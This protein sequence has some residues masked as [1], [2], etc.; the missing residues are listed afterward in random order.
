MHR[1]KVILLSFNYAN[2]FSLANGYLKV[3][4]EKDPFIRDTASIQLLDFDA[5]KHDIRQVLYYLAR[6]QPAIV[7]FS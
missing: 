5:E 6:E 2:H 1:S 3:Y 4:A 7:G